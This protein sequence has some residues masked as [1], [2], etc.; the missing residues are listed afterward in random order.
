VEEIKHTS[1]RMRKGV[2]YQGK[3]VGVEIEKERAWVVGVYGRVWMAC[4]YKVID[5][6]RIKPHV[7]IKKEPSN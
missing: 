2:S 7:P 6:W 3:G 1:G 4:F 5:W